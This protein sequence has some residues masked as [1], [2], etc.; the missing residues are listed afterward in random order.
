MSVPQAA[1]PFLYWLK[2]TYQDQSGQA[3]TSQENIAKEDWDRHA[4]G[5][6]VSIDYLGER[7]E[8]SR[9]A[10]EVKTFPWVGAAIAIGIGLLLLVFSVLIAVSAWRDIV[11]RVRLGRDGEPAL[12]YVT[13]VAAK[14]TPSTIQGKKPSVSYHLQ[15]Q[16][17]TQDGQ[18]FAG[19]STAL[20]AKLRKLWP[21]GTPILIL[22]R[23]E[24]L[25]AHEPD[26]FGA[27]P[28]DLARMLSGQTR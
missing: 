25:S 28:D 24:N 10:S 11:P 3:H 6:T 21:P 7:P 16:F 14:E 12:G 22:Y 15:F 27:R 17:V 5:S 18:E 20:S 1:D 8:G 19:E 23:P 9:L 4:K 13:Q 2:Y 26:L